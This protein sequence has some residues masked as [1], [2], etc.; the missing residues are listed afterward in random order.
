[1]AVALLPAAALAVHESRYRLAFGDDT[2]SVLAEHGHGY[3]GALSPLVAL[4]CAIGCARLLLRVARGIPD[5]TPRAGV[6]RMWLACAA[7]LFAVYG[8]QELLEGALSAG[9]TSGLDAMFAGGGWL[10]V[11]LCGLFG[12]GLALMLR[13]A[14]VVADRRAQRH[15]T[16][17]TTRAAVLPAPAPA[18]AIFTPRACQ[19]ARR[20]AGRAPPLTT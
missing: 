17:A 7:A 15:V 11:P 3:L 10:A 8:G 4:V 12:L 9:H 16:R 13:L 1:M 2:G 6:P 14:H 19:L 20:L 18:A 5:G